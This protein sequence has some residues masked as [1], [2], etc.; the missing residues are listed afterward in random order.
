MPLTMLAEEAVLGG[1]EPSSGQPLKK[2]PLDGL[3]N[4]MIK[5]GDAIEKPQ[6]TSGRG[7]KSCMNKWLQIVLKIPCAARNFF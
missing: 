4:E 3:H 1:S 6:S 5:C 7:Q 2:L